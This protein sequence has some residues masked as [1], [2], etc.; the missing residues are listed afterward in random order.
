MQIDDA[1]LYMDFGDAPV[2]E[3]LI[4]A[5]RAAVAGGVDVVQARLAEDR[6]AP[7][8]RLAELCGEEEAMLVL[9]GEPGGVAESGADGL[10]LESPDSPISLARVTVGD[11]KLVGVTSGSLDEARLALEVGVDYLV[12]RRGAE[13]AGDFA[14]LHD[15]ARVPL[16]AGGLAGLDEAR[17]LVD[18]GVF[19]LCIRA[20]ATDPA[21]VREEAAG[22]ARL[23]GR[24]V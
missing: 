1:F 13:C 3:T 12:H 6:A 11:G 15:E 7:V 21:R 20:R 4:E 9:A 19:R 10:H 8:R 17:G 2:D 24:C 16:F 18:A 14:A 22:Y 5:C 23:L